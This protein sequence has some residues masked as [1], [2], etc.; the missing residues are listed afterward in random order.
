[1]T[2]TPTMAQAIAMGI[3]KNTGKNRRAAERERLAE[4]ET[5][6]RE[7]EAAML[8][9]LDDDHPEKRAYIKL[10]TQQERNRTARAA[11]T[12][13]KPYSRCSVE[14]M[15]PTQKGSPGLMLLSH[16]TRGK[17]HV[18]RATPDLLAIFMP[19]APANFRAAMLGG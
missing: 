3:I 14:F 17:R 11:R 10:R 9:L 7:S 4:I 8:A 6:R 18:L 19:S 1:M 13:G 5:A 12:K 16:P 15:T 2:K